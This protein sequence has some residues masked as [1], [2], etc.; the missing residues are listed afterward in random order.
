LQTSMA[1]YIEVISEDIDPRLIGP[2]AMDRLGA[3]ARQ[4]PPLSFAGFECRLAADDPRV[5]LQVNLNRV[6]VPFPGALLADPV[7]VLLDRLTGDW[8]DSRSDLHRHLNGI[9]MEFDLDEAPP[10]PVPSLFFA[11]HNGCASADIVLNRLA[12]QIPEVLEV[13][14]ALRRRMSDFPPEAALANLGVMLGR[15]PLVVRARMTGMRPADIADALDI[16]R[17]PALDGCRAAL[18]LAETVDGVAVLMDIVEDHAPPAGFE[19]FLHRQHPDEERWRELLGRLVDM[20]ACSKDKRDALLEWPGAVSMSQDRRPAT[21]D[22]G[23]RLLAGRAVSVFWRRVN[24]IKVTP[25]PDGTV[26]AKAYLAFG[27]NWID[28][29]VAELDCRTTAK[30]RSVGSNDESAWCPGEML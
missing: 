30:N 20:G 22:W 14:D 28:R 10:V 9:F 29:R 27:H 4:L 19:L 6:R 3:V 17:N 16:Q 18:A 26:S 24:H 23:D 13:A 1:D 8:V 7:W 15:S 5:D 21:I 12:V 11:L 2:A 25:E